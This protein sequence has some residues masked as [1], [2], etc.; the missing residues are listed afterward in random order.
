MSERNLSN[1]FLNLINRTSAEDLTLGCPDVTG[2]VLSGYRVLEKLKVE[3]GE[4]DLYICRRIGGEYS[5]T[6]STSDRY[7][8]KLFRRPNAVK[9]DVLSRLKSIR[10]P[11][12]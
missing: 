4:A 7:M 2:L 12:R 3:S 5:W 6:V 10:N 9:D 11:C 1:D 8:L